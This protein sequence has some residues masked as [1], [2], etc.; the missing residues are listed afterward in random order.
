M[1]TER[2]S[3]AS[4]IAYMYVRTARNRLRSQIAK[5]RSPRYLAAV[6]MAGLYI[7]WIL[8]GDR[9]NGAGQLSKVISMDAVLPVLSALMLIYAARWW[10][11][12]ADRSALAFAPS[13]IQ[14]LFPAPVSR[15]SLV[16][17]KLV[18]T[19]FAILLNTLIF[20]VLF[21]G[22]G[23]SGEGW[24]RGLALWI[25]FSVLALHRLGASIVRANAI[26]HTRTGWRRSLLPMVVF[27]AL[28]SA[29]AWGLISRLTELRVAATLGFR[30]VADAVVAALQQPIPAAALWPVR[31][32]LAPIFAH[33]VPTWLAALP[34]AFAILLINYLWVI[35]LDA[36]F[37]EAAI[38]ATQY[39]AE[40]IQRFRSSQGMMSRT[41]AGKVARVFPL[42]VRGVPAV[43]VTWKNIAAAVRGGA[44]KTQLV[45]FT[46]GLVIMAIVVRTASKDATDLFIGLTVGWGVMLVFV[47]PSWMRFDLRIDLPRLEILK[48][49]PLPGRHIVAAEIAAVVVLHTTTIWALMSVPIAMVLLEPDLI[50]APSSGL[51]IFLA[52]AIAIPFVNLLMFSIQNAMALLFPAW[53]RMGSDTRGF[54]TM[55]QNLLTMGASLIIAAVAM[56]FPAGIGFL[57]VL[58]GGD[59]LGWTLPLAT[60]A[61]CAILLLEI[62]PAVYWLGDVFERTDILDVQTGN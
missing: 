22:G 19:Q 25:G 32:V 13:E 23:G 36:S 30:A 62:W 3:A 54:E 31:A 4:A 17:A 45:M 2:S 59:V 7:Y 58:F 53:V 48:T 21:R 5:V 11:F 46:I 52:A 28:L 20:T 41:K 10:I 51:P 26:E 35:Q 8:M 44:W 56:V 34:F 1:S 6:A 37:E 42:A 33:D 12:G 15:R 49:W 24:R 39:R 55:G 9:K 57:V 61:G 43:A 47:G 14:F 60:L 38:E 50:S 27:G 29:V 18:R 40:R 16:H